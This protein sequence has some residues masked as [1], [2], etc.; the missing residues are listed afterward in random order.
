MYILNNFTSKDKQIM[1]LV[2]L[3]VLTCTR[4]NI[5][6]RAKHLRGIDNTI[7]DL[8]SRKQV[9]KALEL[10]PNLQKNPE[11]VPEHLLLHRLL[12]M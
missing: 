2:R 5:L 7:C 10:A 12:Q 8:I 1:I 4:N 6:I 9:Q 3:L 11:E